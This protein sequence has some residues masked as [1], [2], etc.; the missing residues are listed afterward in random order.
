[1]I[2]KDFLYIGFILL[3]IAISIGL[4]CTKGDRDETSIEKPGSIPGIGEMPGKPQGEKFTLPNGVKL[5]GDIVGQEDG[6][7]SQDCVFDGQGFFVIVKM[8]LQADSSAT[9]NTEVEF[10]AGLVIT[11]A[12][13]GFQHGL[14]V[15]RVVVTVPPIMPGSGGNNCQ[16]SLMLFCLNSGRKPSDASAKYNLGPVTNSP[17]LK[18]FINRLSPKKIAYSAFPPNDDTWKMIEEDL[19][20]VL[21][22][23]TNGNGLTDNDLEI[24]KNLPNK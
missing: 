11:T 8:A 23:I 15:E 13:E 4:S 18:D 24:I 10:P 22:H 14:L 6:P 3:L 7:S 16:V 20:S 19:Q 9:G 17:L 21:W 1:M 2:K 5:K 12:S